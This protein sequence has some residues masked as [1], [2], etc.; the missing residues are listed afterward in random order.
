MTT[1]LQQAPPV[2]HCPTCRHLPATPQEMSHKETSSCTASGNM[3][4]ARSLTSASAT[5]MPDPMPTPPPT[6]CWSTPPRKRYGG[7]NRHA[8]PNERISPH[9]S[10]RWMDLPPRMPAMLS[11]AS[12]ASLP[13][14]GAGH[15]PTWQTST[16]MSLAIVRSN[17]LLLCGDRD[18][19][20]HRCAPLD[21]TAVASM[22]SLCNN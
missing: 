10:T 2:L 21:G 4:G 22:K 3:P 5:Q 16:R 17:T 14:N 20:L 12:L 13:L 18:N 1:T 7:T 11:T 6:K 19:S 9:S 8:S 15:T